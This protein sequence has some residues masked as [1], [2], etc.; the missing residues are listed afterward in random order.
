MSGITDLGTK[1]HMQ[2]NRLF[3]LKM[4]VNILNSVLL[5]TT[6]TSPL[7]CAHVCTDKDH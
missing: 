4:Q 7:I 2:Q 1:L 5:L 6:C 3:F